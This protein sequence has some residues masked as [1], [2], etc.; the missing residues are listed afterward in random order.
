MGVRVVMV[1]G[2]YSITAASIAS[3]VGIL[4]NMSYDTY[5]KLHRNK[6]NQK[7]LKKSI[8][9]IGKEINQL[10]KDEWK[11][12]CN[13]YPEVILSRATPSHK[14]LCVKE[15]QENGNSVLMVG[16]GV[17]DLPAMRQADVSV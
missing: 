9:I 3:Q 10:T 2:D 13:H 12:I 1:T 14:L 5:A 7:L 8:I 16:D 11:I 15:Y 6:T 17:N 4:S